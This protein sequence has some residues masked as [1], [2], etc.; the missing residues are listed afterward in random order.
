MIRMRDK[1]SI[2]ISRILQEDG[3]WEGGE[4]IYILLNSRYC[5]VADY[6]V[7]EMRSVRVN[8]DQ[9]GSV[10]RMDQMQSFERG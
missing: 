7:S 8:E 1:T 6:C 3:G 2:G 5:I 10:E 9:R 4:R